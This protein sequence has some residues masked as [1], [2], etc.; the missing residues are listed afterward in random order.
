M[1]NKTLLRTARLC[2]LG[3]K[4]RLLAGGEGGSVQPL[5]RQKE[6]LLYAAAA[7]KKDEETSAFASTQIQFTTRTRNHKKVSPG[8]IQQHLCF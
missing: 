5:A 1:K 6:C 8:F 3:V 2:S 4:L 7:D